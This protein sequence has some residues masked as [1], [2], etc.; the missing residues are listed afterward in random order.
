MIYVN[1]RFL[2][3]NLT[4][5]NRFAY[6]MCRAWS[7]MGI[8]FVLCCPPGKIKECYDTSGFSIVVYGWGKSH[9]WEQLALPF[10][11]RRIK[12]EKIL[13][14]FTGL[15][16]LLERNK[17]MTI[18]DL[19]FMANPRWYSRFYVL[20]YK[21]MTPL[22]AKTSKRIL[23]V[24]K[25]SQ[26][27]IEQRLGIDKSDIS[28]IYNA[29]SESFHDVGVKRSVSG[30]TMVEDRYILAVSSIDPRK[31]FLVLLK[32][33]EYVEDPTIKLY[34]IGGQD[35][36]YMASV[37]SLSK[38]NSS[39]RIKWLGR[40]SDAELKNYYAHA[41]CFVY[42]SLYEGFGIPPLEAMACGTPVIVSAIPSLEEVCGDAALY[43][44]PYDEKDIAKAINDI[45]SLKGLRDDLR[46]RG[47]EH[48]SQFS[49]KKSARRLMMVVDDVVN[50]HRE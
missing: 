22:C 20:W 48:S 7:R 24:S 40:V 26:S 45:V 28:V 37:S 9:V 1:G 29:V 10:W 5:V 6:E 30:A 39:G 19:A 8:R 2:L 36:I 31:N 46:A 47:I 41:L 4:G 14:S 27:E 32:A 18:H 17:I 11:F 50:G 3:Q 38:V 12:G 49:W 42:P 33:F 43:V 16:P 44:N 35:S 23:T 25:F 21:L 13:I 34:I 15:G